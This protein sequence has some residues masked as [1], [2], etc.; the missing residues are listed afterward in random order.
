MARPPLSVSAKV[1]KRG[2]S[3]A[4]FSAACLSLPIFIPWVFPLAWFGLVPFF[5]AINSN[6]WKVA[7]AVSLVFGFA[8]HGSV[9]YWLVPTVADL[10]PYTEL[11][12][13]MMAVWAIVAFVAL[14]L[15]QSLFVVLLGLTSWAIFQRTKG[16]LAAIGIGSAWLLTEWLRSIGTFGYPWALL[17]STQV[18]FLPLAQWASFV[19]SFGL[20]GVIAFVNALL[21]EWLRCRN[22]RF[23]LAALISLIL[24]SL[25]GW[26]EMVR[27]E[28]LLRKASP[29]T[30]GVVQGNFGKERWRPD[31]TFAELEEI[32]QTHLRL[33]EQA[34]RKGARIIVW[35]E[36]ALPW[37]LRENGRWGYGAIEIQRFAEKHKVVLFVGAGEWREDKSYNACFLF[38]PK[39]TIVGNEVYRKIRLVPFGEY[40]PGRALF[41]WLE[42]ILPHAPVE[43]APG[44]RWEMTKLLLGDAKLTLK[45]ATAICFE[46]LFPFHLRKLIGI[47]TSQVSTAN[48]LV[49]ITNDSWF[50]DT[51][52]PRHHA[53]VAIFRAIELRKGV[54]RGA[55]TGIS[56]IVSPTGRVLQFADW[57]QRQ[58]LVAPIPVVSLRSVYQILGD[59]PFVVFSLVVLVLIFC[60]KSVE[61]G[62]GKR[63]L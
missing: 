13:Q 38:A 16:T 53:R 62:G 20:S 17:A 10:G 5:V 43:T 56:M 58:V 47:P 29:L 21:F 54:A 55:G 50:G 30:V 34:A 15:W 9:N 1:E 7:L 18:S 44:N 63:V 57:N 28:L 61:K 19:G 46:S 23:L 2:I 45:V 8:F 52:A 11:Q 60:K 25:I 32:L 51:L 40:I 42:K 12:N 14:V 41:P 35:S 59:L 37:R 24:I 33:S 22:K 39:N 36:T 27:I 26:G 6:R 31:V 4:I 49:I 48:L 3:L